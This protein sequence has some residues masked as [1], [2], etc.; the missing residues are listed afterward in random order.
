MWSE[1]HSLSFQQTPFGF[2]IL[3][4]FWVV[5]WPFQVTVT[6][7][8]AFGMLALKKVRTFVTASW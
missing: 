8:L 1:L 7:V 6:N 2:M 5:L 3:I 4:H